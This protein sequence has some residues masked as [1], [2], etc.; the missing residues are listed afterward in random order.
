[1]N[2][3]CN[4]PPSPSSSNLWSFVLAT[5]E[6]RRTSRWSINFQS[7]VVPTL[8]ILTTDDPIKQTRN[9]HQNPSNPHNWVQSKI[10]TKIKIYTQHIYSEKQKKLERD[11]KL[12]ELKTTKIDKLISKFKESAKN[13][14]SSAA[15]A[16]RGVSG[17]WT[18]DSASPPPLFS[19]THNPLSNGMKCV[20]SF[21]PK[22]Q[23]ER[24]ATK[25]PDVSPV[26]Q[27][28]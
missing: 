28:G 17:E 5:A 4:Q 2:L 13:D 25:V 8:P 7:P 26:S 1:M 23:P 14:E 19:L 11:R 20:L 3:P 24:E 21:D 6:P 22:N 10:E 18:V 16:I 12:T 27:S 9:S 15:K